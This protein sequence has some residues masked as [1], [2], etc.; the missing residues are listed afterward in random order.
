M[1]KIILSNIFILFNCTN[2]FAYLLT[3]G[4]YTN[5]STRYVSQNEQ[6]GASASYIENLLESAKAKTD[7]VEFLVT[8]ASY[9]SMYMDEIIH[10]FV[11]DVDIMST[12]T[13]NLLDDDVM[14]LEKKIAEE[15]QNIDDKLGEIAH[16]DGMFKVSLQN[17]QQELDLAKEAISSLD[18]SE[19]DSNQNT[20]LEEV[21][22]VITYSKSRFNF[23][24]DALNETLRVLSVKMDNICEK[25]RDIV[26][27]K[28]I[29]FRKNFHLLRILL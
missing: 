23:M 18:E 13:A 29:E 16:T 5:A 7:E 25:A 8:S 28:N 20:L 4:K 2:N 21:A 11:D 6:N 14:F 17:V 3:Y 12:D 9:E 1:N 19:D 27:A 10:T 24:V 15:V 26:R 22:S